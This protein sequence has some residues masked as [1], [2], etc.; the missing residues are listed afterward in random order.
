MIVVTA[1]TCGKSEKSTAVMTIP[2]V[3]EEKVEEVKE[4]VT[5][6]IEEKVEEIE[7]RIQEALPSLDIPAL[8]EVI[9]ELPVEVVPVEVEV[10]AEVVPVLEDSL[11]VEDDT[12]EED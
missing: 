7:S 11:K 6:T 9:K 12:N 2:E 1:L 3:I 4:I 10:P 8:K 5:T